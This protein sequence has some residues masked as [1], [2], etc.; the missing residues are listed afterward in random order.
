[1]SGCAPVEVGV[2][3]V[4]DRAGLVLVL[5]SGFVSGLLGPSPGEG[6]WLIWPWGVSGFGLE[7]VSVG[8]VGESL[9]LV[10]TAIQC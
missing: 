5:L 8:G 10:G 2:V 1:M 7:S 3:L 9:P 6:G 4:K